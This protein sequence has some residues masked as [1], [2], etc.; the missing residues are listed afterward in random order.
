VLQQA[1][2]SRCAVRNHLAPTLGGCRASTATCSVG[3]WPAWLWLQ[4]VYADGASGAL[5]G[6]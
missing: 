1:D 6:E 2:A 4:L 5:K 3:Y